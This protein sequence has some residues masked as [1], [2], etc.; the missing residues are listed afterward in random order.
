MFLGAVAFYHASIFAWQVY[1]APHIQPRGGE[2]RTGS[3]YDPT[4]VLS[5]PPSLFKH[6]STLQ[7]LL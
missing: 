5:F 4:L 3:L 6:L 7:H 2:R 1:G